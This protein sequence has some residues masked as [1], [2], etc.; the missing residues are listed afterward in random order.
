MFAKKIHIQL[1]ALVLLLSIFNSWS[2]NEPPTLTATGDQVYCPLSEI[3]VATDFE[4]TD[5]DDAQIEALNIQIST[6]YEISYETLELTGNHPNINAV[7]DNG[8]GKLTLESSN[9]GLVNLSDLNAAAKDVIFKSTN[10]QPSGERYFSFTIGNANYLPSTGHYYEYVSDPLITWTEARDAA[11]NRYYFGLQ[12]YLVT[13]LSEEEA[14]MSGEQ[15][16]GVGWIG[17]SDAFNEGEWKW[18]TGPENGTVFWNGD[19]NGSTPNFAFWNTNEPNNSGGEDY[20]HI[21]ASNIGIPGSWN[22]LPNEGG[23][24]DYIAQG[25][26]VEYGGMP[27]DPTLDISASTKISIPSIISTSVQ[28]PPTCGGAQIQLTATGTTGTTILWYDSETSTTP[29]HTGTAFTTPF[30]S[31]PT[32][33]YAYA[34]YGYGTSEECLVGEKTTLIAHINEI[35]TIIYTSGDTICEN[36]SGELFAEAQV[37]ETINWYDSLTS[38]TILGTGSLFNTPVVSTTTAFYAE[39]VYN[40]CIGDRTNVFLTVQNVQAP[41]TTQTSQSFC[42]F[43]NATIEDIY[44]TGIDVQWYSSNTSTTPLNDSDLLIDNATYY[45]SQ[46]IDDCESGAR[47]AVN[48]TLL[49]TIIPETI[50]PFELCDDTSVGTDNDGQIIFNL[51]DYDEEILNGESASDFVITY[52]TDIDYNNQIPL[53]EVSNFENTSNPQTIYVR[54]S[55]TLN[56]ACYTDNS[57]ELVVNELPDLL[58][59]S[60]TLTECDDDLNGLEDFNLELKNDELSTDFQNE[61]FTYYETIQEA[62]DGIIGTEIQNPTTYQNQTPDFDTV[63]VRIENNNQCFKVVEINLDV[64]PSSAVMDNFSTLNFYECDNGLNTEDGIAIFDFSSATAIIKAQFSPVDVDVYYYETEAEANQLINEI[65]PTNHENTNSPHTQDIWVRI[66]S[67]LGSD[68]LAKGIYVKLNTLELPQFEARHPDT[69]FCLNIGS[70]LIET[71]N[72]NGSYQYEWFDEAGNLI[73]NTDPTTETLTITSGGTY[74]VIASLFYPNENITCYST[75]REIEVIES[76]PA[77]LSINDLLITDDS[78]NNTITINTTNLGIGDYEFSLAGGLYQDEPFFDN[79][80]PGI[81]ILSVNDKNDC[82]EF[83]IEV[84]VIGFPR[85]FTPNNDGENDTW[86]IK[87]VGENFFASSLIHIYDR[88]GKIVAKVDPTSDGWNGYYNGYALPSSDYWFT[89]ELIDHE[90]NIRSKKG[91]FSLIRRSY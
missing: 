44:V 28:S 15:A 50:E 7:W 26:V 49:N 59:T 67:E 1:F 42:D 40:G 84:S 38:T 82:G 71:F 76:T 89:A 34:S 23:T 58:T 8:Q 43:D 74:S 11:E 51:N 70:S 45:A 2:Q 87:G 13:I 88:F 60:V 21:T 75:P 5:A 79:V 35:P 3:N 20:A 86:Q 41:T 61:T 10:P 31:T 30:I 22:D 32:I 66:T 69:A 56:N 90:G 27:G 52:F 78:E 48:V 63:Y 12:G 81:H 6:G 33:Y 91:H 65:D 85:F 47:L 25:Y 83:S 53:N 37:A 14:Q 57:F 18:V 39:P 68:C 16:A 4:I 46:T 29:I 36:G 55:S 80:A 72:A 17:G 77:I 54:V 64:N 24:F 73:P 62:N 9:G 19:F